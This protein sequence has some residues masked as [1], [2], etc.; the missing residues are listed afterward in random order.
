[1][2]SFFFP[3]FVFACKACRRVIQ[4]FYINPHALLNDN[5]PAKFSLMY[6]IRCTSV[7]IIEKL[8]EEGEVL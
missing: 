1:M 4:I 2:Q 6:N 8:E 5:L 7:N 3:F